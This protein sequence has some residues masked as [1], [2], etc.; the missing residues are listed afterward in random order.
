M[1]NNIRL[2]AAALFIALT[3]LAAA[4]QGSATQATP[5]SGGPMVVERVGSGFMFAPDFKV[6]EVDGHTSGLAGGYAG[7]LADETFFIGGGG[8]WLVNG[9]DSRELAYGGLILQFMG[10]TNERVGWSFKGLLGGGEGTLLDTVTV[11][12][13]PPVYPT[14]ADGHYPD[15]TRPVPGPPVTQTSLV[16]AHQD[17]FVAEP[18]ANVVFRL[19]KGVR[20]AGGVGYRFVDSWH[21]HDPYG[22]G[23]GH[24][25]GRFSGVTGT[26]SLQ[27]GGGF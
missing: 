3:P 9:S 19:A 4:A 23:Y 15:G 26:I 27:I 1:T 5:T 24:D 6:T 16:R 8:Y 13:Y 18:E 25:D 11:V 17:F 7:W 2:M 22:Y 20:L 10:R 12:T 14:P 21:Y